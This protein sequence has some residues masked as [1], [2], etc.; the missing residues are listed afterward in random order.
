LRKQG[1]SAT[2]ASI[3][4]ERTAL[5]P[6]ANQRVQ[7]MADHDSKQGPEW[8]SALDAYTAKVKK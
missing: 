1:D 8:Q 3:V 7:T 4:Y 6:A 2:V 5:D